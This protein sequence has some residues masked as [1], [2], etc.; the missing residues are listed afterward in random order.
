MSPRR[1][2]AAV[3]SVAGLLPRFSRRWLSGTVKEPRSA[4]PHVPAWRHLFADGQNKI[5]AT[6]TNSGLAR[7]MPC[8]L[9][10]KS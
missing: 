2:Q 9:Q 4:A 7:V 3:T 8:T 10:P 1:E 5:D 6:A